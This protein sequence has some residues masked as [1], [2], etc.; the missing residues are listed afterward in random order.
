VQGVEGA[1]ARVGNAVLPPAEFVGQL[2][3][4]LDGGEQA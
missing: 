3:R 2:R 4:D 1:P